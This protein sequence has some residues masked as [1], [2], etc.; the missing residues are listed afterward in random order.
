MMNNEHWSIITWLIGV[1]VSSVVVVLGAVYYIA[2]MKTDSSSFKVFTDGCRESLMTLGN[3]Y[4]E[5]RTE[6]VQNFSKIASL[7][8]DRKYFDK[9][10]EEIKLSILSVDRKV[11][12]INGGIVASISS[13]RSTLEKQMEINQKI[14]I[15]ATLAASRK[16]EGP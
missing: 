13:F 5:I 3:N 16:R 2:K 14:I 8:T 7:E 11:H 15:D 6:Q 9:Q 1:N 10:I 12:E 4:K